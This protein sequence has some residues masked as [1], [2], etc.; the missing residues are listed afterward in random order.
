MDMP[1]LTATNRLPRLPS[2]GLD[3]CG[4]HSLQATHT[5]PFIESFRFVAK[6][7]YRRNTRTSV[8]PC[9]PYDAR[10]CPLGVWVVFRAGYVENIWDH[11]AG[12]VVVTEAGGR[13]SD[14]KGRELDFAPG[15]PKIV[16]R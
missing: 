7:C 11:A 5:L 14:V 4:I 15:R 10:L 16:Y 1:Q 2:I 13:V 9:P 12:A 8:R 6:G 3:K